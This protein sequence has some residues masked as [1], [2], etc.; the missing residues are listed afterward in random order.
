MF[1]LSTATRVESTKAAEE[2]GAEGLGYMLLA[3]LHGAMSLSS[4]GEHIRYPTSSSGSQVG[5][6]VETSV[7]DVCLLLRAHRRVELK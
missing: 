5:G 1:T 7:T 6:P 3:P 4:C 2:Y